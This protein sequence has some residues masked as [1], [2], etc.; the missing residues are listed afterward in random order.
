MVLDTHIWIWWT[1][2]RGNLSPDENSLLTSAN[3]SGL[4]ISVISIWEVAKLVEKGRIAFQIPLSE[5]LGKAI[6]DYGIEVIPLTNSIIV[7]STSLPGSFHND[8]CDQIIVATSRIFS[9]PIL[10]RDAK[11]LNYPFVEKG[12]TR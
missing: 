2:S 1:S 8:P 12:G 5:W 4:K 7:E 10:T 11:I 6:A 9:E 3:P